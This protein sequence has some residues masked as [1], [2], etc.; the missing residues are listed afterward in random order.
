MAATRTYGVQRRPGSHRATLPLSLG[1]FPMQRRLQLPNLALR[2]FDHPSPP[3]QMARWNHKIPLPSGTK[4]PQTRRFN[5]LWKRYQDRDGGIWLLAT[6][7]GQFP[8]LAKLFADSAY[9]GSIFHTALGKVLPNLK[10][11]IVRRSDRAK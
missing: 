8:F 6:L 7:F 3:K 5:Q 9:A 10:T 1:H 4:L 2:A 11:E